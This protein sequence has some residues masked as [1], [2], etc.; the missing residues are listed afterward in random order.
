MMCYSFSL[1]G[2]VKVITIYACQ[3]T[4]CADRKLASL[5]H[6]QRGIQTHFGS[7]FFGQVIHEEILGD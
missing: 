2:I 7:D 4:S 1:A 3:F 5:V 6:A